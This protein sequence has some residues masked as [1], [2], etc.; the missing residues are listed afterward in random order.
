M[1]IELSP[2]LKCKK[3]GKRIK[4]GHDTYGGQNMVLREN[5]GEINK[6]FDVF[7]NCM[8]CSEQH[9]GM[10][11]IRNGIFRGV[12]K[13]ELKNPQKKSDCGFGLVEGAKLYD[14]V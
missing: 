10:A 9:V 2:G 1:L 4:I 7:V 11:F 13:Y 5:Q 12:Y 6:D 8:E 3:C 14:D